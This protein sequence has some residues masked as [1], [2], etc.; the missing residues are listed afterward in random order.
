MIKPNYYFVHT[1]T[2]EKKQAITE[3]EIN[4]LFSL[5]GGL[6]YSGGTRNSATNSQLKKFATLLLESRNNS[7]AVSCHPLTDEQIDNL[8]RS[9]LMPSASHAS[10]PG[11]YSYAQIVQIIRAVEQRHNIKENKS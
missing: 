3:T 10:E 5:A 2:S 1:N 7:N 11:E 6:S 4:Y 9:T 8:L